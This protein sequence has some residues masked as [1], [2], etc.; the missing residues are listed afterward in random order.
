M[1]EVFGWAH[2]LNKNVKEAPWFYV[3]YLAM[4]VSAG[5]VVLIPNAPLVAITMYVQVV[6]V[7]LLPISLVFM[8]LLLNDRQFMGQHVNTHWQNVI[9][10]GIVVFVILMSTS[11]AIGTMFPDLFQ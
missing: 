2:S 7:T 9:N 8:I 1:G 4:L 11:M 3:V 10:I 6:A 5:A